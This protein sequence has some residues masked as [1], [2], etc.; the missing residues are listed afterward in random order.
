[1]LTFQKS[2]LPEMA[3]CI[4]SWQ[5]QEA[6]GGRGGR[7]RTRRREGGGVVPLLK[8]RDPHLAGKM[9]HASSIE[10]LSM[11]RMV[12][13]DLLIG[14]PQQNISHDDTKPYFKPQ[15][16]FDQK[17]PPQYQLTSPTQRTQEY[18]VDRIPIWRSSGKNG[19]STKNGLSL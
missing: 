5:K 7:R 17:P 19:G 9:D 1:M 8:S 12:Y 10:T 15:N 14:S 11:L 4:R 6:E 2:S 13:L 16:I 18:Y 3:H